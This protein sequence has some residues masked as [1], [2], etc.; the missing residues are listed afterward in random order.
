MLPQRGMPS[1]HDS[2]AIMPGSQ[3]AFTKGAIDELSERFAGQGATAADLPSRVA[4]R[5]G[6]R[7]SNA[8]A[9]CGYRAGRTAGRGSV[10][11]GRADRH[12][13][14]AGQ[15]AALGAWRRCFNM[16]FAGAGGGGSGT[17]GARRGSVAP[18]GA[19]RGSSDDGTD[20]LDQPLSSGLAWSGRRHSIR[21]R[22]LL[23]HYLHTHAFSRI[24]RHFCRRA[25]RG[26]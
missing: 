2:R 19:R 12:D 7:A 17:R 18:A 14:M 13:H 11:G 26:G 20:A 6:N 15:R 8:G 1:R 9:I 22:T 10:G 23:L 16:R 24:R 4:H 3:Q 21:C 25:A 5:D